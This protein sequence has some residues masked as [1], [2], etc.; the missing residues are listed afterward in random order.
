MQRDDLNYYKTLIDHNKNNS[1]ADTNDVA[2]N[3]IY[4]AMCE[5][6]VKRT[7]SKRYYIG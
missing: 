3:N 6:Y 5:E 7:L 1:N 4:K 2:D